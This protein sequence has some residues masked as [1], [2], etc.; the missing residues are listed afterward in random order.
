MALREGGIPQDIVDV[1]ANEGWLPLASCSTSD[2]PQ[3]HARARVPRA[4]VHGEARA[5]RS[6][7]LIERTIRRDCWTRLVQRTE[8]EFVQEFSHPLPM[9]VIAELIGVLRRPISRASRPGRTRSSNRS[10]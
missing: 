10:A 8:I 9:I 2:P 4:A 5:R 3:P 7:P 1:Y 6:R